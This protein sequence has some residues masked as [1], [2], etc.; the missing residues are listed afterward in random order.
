M[1]LLESRLA[2]RM[3][4]SLLVA[5]LLGA[6][7]ASASSPSGL[8]KVLVIPI[9]LGSTVAELCPDQ[10]CP[11]DLLADAPFYKTPRHTAQD[12]ENLLNNYG[13]R[14]WQFA[15]YGQSQAQFNVLASP[16]SQNGWWKPPHSAE[17]YYKNGDVFEDLKTAAFVED[18]A[19]GA[20]DTIC[21][22][23]PLNCSMLGQFDRLIV[24][25]NKQSR[26]GVSHG[27]GVNT[28]FGTFIF[29]ATFANESVNDSD[30]MSVMMHE[31]G[32]QLGMP[33]H[34]GDCGPDYVPKVLGSLECVGRWDIM[35]YDW[36][37]SQPTGYS[38]LSRGWIDPNS[39][40]SYDL[41]SGTPVSTLTFIRPVEQAPDGIPN[42]VRLSIGG[43]D[44]PQ[45]FGYFAECRKRINGD[46][47]IFPNSPGAPEEGLLITRVHEFDYPPVHAVRRNFPPSQN[48]DAPITLQPGDSFSD[49]Q[50]GLFV[51]L[52]GYA[53]DEDQPL[54]LVEVDYLKNP[55]QGPLLLWQNL[56]SPSP[57]SGFGSFD[58]G[59]NH[60]LP[61]GDVAGGPANDQPLKIEPPWPNHNNVLFARAH[62]AGTL[63]VENVRLNV[64]ISQPAIFTSSCGNS[65][66]AKTEAVRIARVDPVT[67]GVSM[68]DFRP[69]PSDS[70]GVQMHAPADR[71]TGRDA[72][73]TVSTRIA[74]EFF[75][76]KSGSQRTR[77]V[78]KSNEGCGKDTTFHISPA[79]V[80]PGWGVVVDPQIVDLPAGARAEVNVIV[81]PPP[82][83]APG[84]NAEIRID[85]S[86]VEDTDRPT[87]PDRPVDPLLLKH[88][89]LIG[90]L[91]ISARVVGDPAL[92]HLS[93]TSASGR[94]GP[95]SISGRIVP[96]VSNGNVLLEYRS[97][98]VTQTRFVVTDDDGAFQDSGV[99]SSARVQAFWP[100]DASH[101][102]AESRPCEY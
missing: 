54:C 88:I 51:R 73:N 57:E 8:Q 24:L 95:V 76:S 55:V 86:Q 43:L 31:F 1:K 71:A 23:Q 9:D 15:S 74:F 44:W 60:P 6:G 40:L 91:Q 13:T 59:M 65:T 82:G 19:R 100:G 18:A 96:P 14:Y 26:G 2:E 5:A 38:R 3:F 79:I 68:L 22:T 70:L 102:P 63:P 52:N 30:A 94:G 66:A 85:V 16:F 33:T 20:I 7:P 27:A 62:T 75:D 61:P 41:L 84:E 80:P 50:L 99:S 47:G 28:L 97:R 77:F 25:S 92:V 83:T 35:G 11:A 45:F 39:T 12:W 53:G 93:C 4:A 42:L 98:G 72:S 101:S 56:V 46:E 48:P 34:Y 87:L 49:P 69:H 90:S 58:I 21:I 32:H 67:G 78:L 29:S 10:P 37:W 36:A 64:S 81:T 17:D 89:D